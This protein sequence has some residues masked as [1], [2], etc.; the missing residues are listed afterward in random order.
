MIPLVTASEEGKAQSW[1]LVGIAHP[2]CKLKFLSR[3]VSQ[4]NKSSG[5]GRH[6]G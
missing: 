6:R 1:N 4:V 2:D 5:K 3:L